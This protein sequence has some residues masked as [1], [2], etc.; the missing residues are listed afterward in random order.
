MHTFV[1]FIFLEDMLLIA[2]SEVRK[3][4]SLLASVL[5]IYSIYIHTH[6]FSAAVFFLE[7]KIT[8]LQERVT[9]DEFYSYQSNCKQK[10][11]LWHFSLLSVARICVL[12]CPSTLTAYSFFVISLATKEKVI[13]YVM[14]LYSLVNR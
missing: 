10:F 13:G 14:T 3:Q 5:E 11:T 8:V 4:T 7:Y 6:K 1:C 9:S 2:A 12:V